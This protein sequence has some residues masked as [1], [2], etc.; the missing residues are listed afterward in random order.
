MPWNILNKCLCN[1]ID[2]VQYQ[3]TL[4]ET[5]TPRLSGQ[6]EEAF[7][8]YYRKQAEQNEHYFMKN[9]PGMVPETARELAWLGVSFKDI[10]F[11]DW[12]DTHTRQCTIEYI[13]RRRIGI[14]TSLAM[15]H[16]S[17]LNGYEIELFSLGIAR[18]AFIGHDWGDK[19]TAVETVNYIKNLPQG[20]SYQRHMNAIIG[21]NAHQIQALRNGDT[22]ELDREAKQAKE[23]YATNA[24]EAWRTQA[25]KNVEGLY[26]PAIQLIIQYTRKAH[27]NFKLSHEQIYAHRFDAKRYQAALSQRLKT[28]AIVG[29]LEKKLNYDSAHIIA[30]FV[31]N[32]DLPA[33][34]LVNKSASK[35]MMTERNQSA[36]DY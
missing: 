22:Q 28:A 32:K 23:V 34:T 24:P 14:S 11:H 19:R 18:R 15:H 33:V 31:D 3:P 27:L 9:I 25:A 29:F 12:H 30:Q 35:A 7:M 8:P 4:P 1:V 20:T 13:K 21:M 5:Y 17:R 10:R 36:V 26:A 6:R 16:I 2:A